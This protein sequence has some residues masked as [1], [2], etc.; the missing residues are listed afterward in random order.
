MVVTRGNVILSNVTLVTSTNAPT[1]Q[2]SG[3][4][5]T[6][7]NVVI[8]ESTMANQA[9][10]WITGGAVDLGTAASPGGNVFDA[11][12]PGELIHNAG[13]ALSPPSATLLRQ[14]ASPS[15]RP[16]P[17]RMRFSTP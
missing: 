6:L 11:H 8:E 9:A 1:L 16:M 5:V 3:G 17:S 12:G 7:R 13:S 15:P 4:N 10:L 14:T 2:V